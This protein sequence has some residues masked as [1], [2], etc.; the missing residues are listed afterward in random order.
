MKPWEQHHLKGQ[1]AEEEEPIIKRSAHL[2]KEEEELIT[3]M[4]GETTDWRS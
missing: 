2:L 3:R 1:W 4:A